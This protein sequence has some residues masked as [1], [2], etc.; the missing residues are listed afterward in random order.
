[1]SKE[2]TF[3]SY[4]PLNGEK[5]GPYK[6]M[7]RKEVDSLIEKAK[8]T[9]K[10]WSSLSLKKRLEYMKNIVKV[11]SENAEKYIELIHKEYL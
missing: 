6:N 1:M 7:S 8:K 5:M 3:F 9:Q 10:H 4:S 2:S 11:I